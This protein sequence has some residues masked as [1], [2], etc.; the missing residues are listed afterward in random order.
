MRI[1]I[2]SSHLTDS[3]V[4]ASA[5]GETFHVTGSM[6]LRIEIQTCDRQYATTSC[7]RLVLFLGYED[8]MLLL[9]LLHF[10]PD[11]EKLH[12]VFSVSCGWFGRIYRSCQKMSQK[13]LHTHRGFFWHPDYHQ[14]ASS[15][16]LQSTKMIHKIRHFECSQHL[17]ITP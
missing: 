17:T 11:E 5:S 4:L 6:L 7:D 8:D 12:K 15:I 16:S 1:G 10:L 9:C 14:I 3:F 13:S 2:I